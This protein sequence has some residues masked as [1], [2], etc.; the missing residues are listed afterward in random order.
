MTRMRLLTVAAVVAACH[1][2]ALGQTTVSG[3]RYEAQLAVAGGPLV[4]NGAGVRYRGPFKVYAAGLYLSRKA[5][6]PEDAMSA[7]GPKRMSITML[8]DIDSNELGKLFARAIEDNVEKAAFARLVPSV[9]RMGEIFA[10]HKK[11]QSGE[12]FEM[13]WIPGTGTVISVKGKPQGEPFREPDFYN[14]LLRIWLG[15]KPADRDLK[16]ALLGKAG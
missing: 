13:E 10:E 6:T 12:A 9:V 7:P 3:V 15:P 14:A 1:G 2:T 8:R 16:E 11:L 4:L 5:T